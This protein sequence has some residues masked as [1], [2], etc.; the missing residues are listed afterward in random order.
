[1]FWG[2]LGPR[3]IFGS[4]G[5]FKYLT[6]GFLFGPALVLGIYAIQKMRPRSKMWRSVH[7]IALLDG[8]FWYPTTLGEYWSYVWTTMLSWW[9]VK[10]RYLAFWSK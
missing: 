8:A 2:T 9:Y 6:F 1:M 4:N 5:R 10:G 3:K 7:A